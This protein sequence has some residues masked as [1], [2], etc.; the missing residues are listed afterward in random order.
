MSAKWQNRVF[1]QY[2]SMCVCLFV[3]TIT[4]KLLIKNLCNLVDIMC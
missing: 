3:C 4:E 2:L 1:F